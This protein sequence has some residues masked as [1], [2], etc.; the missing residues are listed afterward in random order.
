LS[1]YIEREGRGGVME[2]G[3]GREKREGKTRKEREHS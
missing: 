2:R 1:K 3:K